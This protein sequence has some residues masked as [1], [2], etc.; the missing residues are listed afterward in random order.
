MLICDIAQSPPRIMH[1]L[2]AQPSV[3]SAMLAEVGAGY[4]TR[5]LFPYVTIL[6]YD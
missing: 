4:V 2:Q 6:L 5:G 3:A 1:S